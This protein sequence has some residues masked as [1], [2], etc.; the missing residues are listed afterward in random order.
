MSDKRKKKK[1]A[2]KREQRRLDRLAKQERLV[3]GVEIPRGA[4]IADQS[5]QV[6]NNSYSPP[7]AF[8]VDISFTCRDC[9]TEEVWTA[10][11]Q[12]WYYEVAKGSLFATAVQCRECRN[13]VSDEKYL[14]RRQMERAQED[15]QKD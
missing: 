14:Q 3:D 2:E 12:K 5:Q 8:Y 10:K 7:P 11:Q 6:P 1:L 13:R 15:Q 4:I 9:G